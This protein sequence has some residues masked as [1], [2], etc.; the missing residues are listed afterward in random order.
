M[1]SIPSEVV[2]W[3]WE[4]APD[5]H[6]EFQEWRIHKDKKMI[7]VSPTQIH[8]LRESASRIRIVVFPRLKHLNEFKKASMA[9]SPAGP[10]KSNP[11]A[12]GSIGIQLD[13]RG[14]DTLEYAQAHFM[15]KG[16]TKLVDP[17]YGLERGLATRYGG[18]RRRAL[19]EAYFDCIRIQE[20]A[21]RAFWAFSCLW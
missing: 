11:G 1:T 8:D 5:G 16:N 6:S 12:V 15:T 10:A 17:A 18:W 21:S 14:P 20:G 7:T 9:V 13:A 3:A 4:E 2:R 19:R